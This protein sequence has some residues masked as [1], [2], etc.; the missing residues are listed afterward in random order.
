MT[1]ST[2]SR[3]ASPNPTPP[4]T[5]DN[6]NDEFHNNSL[7]ALQTVEQLKLMDTMDKL[8]GYG[9]SEFV[10]LP[11]IIVCGDQSAGKSSVL[12]VDLPHFPLD[13]L[14]YI[15][16]FRTRPSPKSP[17]RAKKTFVRASRPR[18]SSA[19]RPPAKFR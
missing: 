13:A 4:E 11:Q 17:S 7:D 19:V 9:I 14:S 1:D 3:S 8:R 18:S 10:S 12:E 5:E 16:S 15:L 2:N 6:R